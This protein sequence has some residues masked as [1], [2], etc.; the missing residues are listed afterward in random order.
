MTQKFPITGQ[1]FA[2]QSLFE[3]RIGLKLDHLKLKMMMT[4]APTFMI[5]RILKVV[6]NDQLGSSSSKYHKD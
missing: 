3:L 1:L 4:S 5:V 6:Q 2:V